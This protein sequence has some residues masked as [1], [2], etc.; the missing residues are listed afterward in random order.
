METFDSTMC[1]NLRPLEMNNHMDG[2]D[3][4]FKKNN[5]HPKIPIIPHVK[6]DELMKNDVNMTLP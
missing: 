4:Y 6:F 1:H 3:R 2:G 5:F